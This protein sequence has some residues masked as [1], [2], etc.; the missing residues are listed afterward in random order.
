MQTIEMLNSDFLTWTHV[1]CFPVERRGFL[2]SLT[3]KKED[4]RKNRKN[5]KEEMRNEKKWKEKK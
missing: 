3:G 5:R 1:T 4:K 2:S